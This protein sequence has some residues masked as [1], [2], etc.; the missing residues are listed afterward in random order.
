M[1]QVAF[2]RVS[3]KPSAARSRSSLSVLKSAA[4]HRAA[5]SRS[6]RVE[7]A[8]AVYGFMPVNLQGAVI[9]WPSL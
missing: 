4:L 7:D 3:A 5:S 1:K 6:V 9:R 2:S 8:R